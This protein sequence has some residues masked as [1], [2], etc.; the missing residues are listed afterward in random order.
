MCSLT[1][2]T[3]AQLAAYVCRGETVEPRPGHCN[4]I[5]CRRPK[6]TWKLSSV[7]V[8]LLLLHMVC[9]VPMCSEALGTAAR[10]SW[11][12]TRRM[13]SLVMTAGVQ[14][15]TSEQQMVQLTGVP[16]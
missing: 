10:L 15:V 14:T 3:D 8:L 1:V 4:R 9:Q 13:G 12:R 2:S 16:G 6:R 11:K 7:T 5:S